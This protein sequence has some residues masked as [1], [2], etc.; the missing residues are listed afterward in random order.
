MHDGRS[1]A[2]KGGYQM[3][4]GTLAT[5]CGKTKY[6]ELDDVRKLFLQH[7]I[8]TET[9]GQKWVNWQHAWYWFVNSYPDYPSFRVWCECPEELQDPIQYQSDG[10]LGHGWNCTYCSRLVQVG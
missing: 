3:S 6:E 8:G 4:S 2:L 1:K 9:S 10:A 5:L 7:I